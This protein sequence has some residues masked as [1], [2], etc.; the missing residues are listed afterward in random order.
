KVS[1]FFARG[2]WV[3]HEE[4]MFPT[5]Y[6]ANSVGRLQRSV[7]N[8]R[9]RVERLERV[10]LAHSF[11]FVKPLYIA[12]LLFERLIDR[13]G[14]DVLKA[15]I[16]GLFVRA[17]ARAP[18]PTG[19]GGL[20]SGIRRPLGYSREWCMRG[21]ILGRRMRLATKTPVAMRSS[22]DDSGQPKWT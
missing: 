12:S 4:D 14:L 20:V 8:A 15:E 6:R 21:N 11:G 7:C 19:A 3:D 2:E 1:Y 10:A 5:F 13:R 22:H 18:A 9:F 17:E 16:L